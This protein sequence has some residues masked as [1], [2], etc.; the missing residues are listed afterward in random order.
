MGLSLHTSKKDNDQW[1]FSN[2]SPLL[3][4]YWPIIII[5]ESSTW[6]NFL[7]SL[8]QNLTPLFY[9][10]RQN[11]KEFCKTNELIG[12]LSLCGLSLKY[13]K[14]WYMS[15]VI[16]AT[17]ILVLLLLF[18]SFFVFSCYK[19]L[20]FFKCLIRWQVTFHSCLSNWPSLFTSDK[21][22]IWDNSSMDSWDSN[23]SCLP[24]IAGQ[25]KWH[26]CSRQYLMD[27]L[28]VYSSINEFSNWTVHLSDK[29]YINGRF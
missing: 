4:C 20:P 24:W 27:L 7:L 6:V 13:L 29:Y 11:L 14:I 12:I 2:I 16:L 28:K 9:N 19:R 3:K 1:L 22:Q 23:N 26:T 10:E 5:V 21:S 8:Y 17:Y 18:L 15:S 25:W